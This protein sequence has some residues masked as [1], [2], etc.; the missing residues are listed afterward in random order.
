MQLTAFGGLICVKRFKKLHRRRYHDGHVPVFCRERKTDALRLCAVREVKLHAG[1]V[2]QHVPL[3]EDLAEFS[4]VL[5]DDGGVRYNINHTFHTVLNG[6]MQRKC[7]RTGR[8]A[9]AGRDIQP[10]YSAGF[11]CGFFALLGYLR[12]CLLNRSIDRELRQLFLYP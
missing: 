3:A 7:E 2:L 10:V 6:M 12:P 11:F 8:F 1:V 4:G 9:A 5:L